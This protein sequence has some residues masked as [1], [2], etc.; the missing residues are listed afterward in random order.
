MTI[1]LAI[2]IAALSGFGVFYL[3]ML[4]GSLLGLVQRATPVAKLFVPVPNAQT[5]W[6]ALLSL[7]ISVGVSIWAFYALK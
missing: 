1:G 7:A 3:M 4:L 2:L 5:W 6:G